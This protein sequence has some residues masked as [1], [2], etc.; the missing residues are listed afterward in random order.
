MIGWVQASADGVEWWDNVG[1]VVFAEVAHMGQGVRHEGTATALSAGTEYHIRVVARNYHSRRFDGVPPSNIITATPYDTLAP[2]PALIATQVSACLS[3]A[4]GCA[5]CATNL[6]RGT[7]AVTLVWGA[8]PG[9]V[10]GYRIQVNFDFQACMLCAKSG[11]PNPAMI[12][13]PAA[14]ASNPCVYTRNV[15][16]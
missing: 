6:C 8:P 7:G 15:T 14:R 11:Y 9:P 16:S 10:T 12:N 4:C 3:A 5:C 13:V 1:G 2:V